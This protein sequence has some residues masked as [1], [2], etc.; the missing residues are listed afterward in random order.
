MKKIVLTGAPYAGKSTVIEAL[1]ERGYSVVPEAAIMV[2]ETLQGLIPAGHIAWRSLYY[3]SF[4]WLI[5]KKQHELESAAEAIETSKDR[6]L[7][8]LDRGA[9]DGIAFA[10]HFMIE[11]PESCMKLAMKSKYDSVYLLDLVKPFDPR[12]GTGRIETEDDCHQLQA[13]LGLVYINKGYEPIHVPFMSVDDR[14]DF[15]LAKELQV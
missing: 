4:Q 13:F 11:F 15:I 10:M 8:F 2:I 5:S 3:E 1:R 7:L 12:S 6:G 14:V 9:F